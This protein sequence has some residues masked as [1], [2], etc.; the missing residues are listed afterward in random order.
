MKKMHY[1]VLEE[2]LQEGKNCLHE[3]DLYL[4]EHPDLRDS[5]FYSKNQATKR[6]KMER[7]LGEKNVSHSSSIILLVSLYPLFSS[8]QEVRETCLFGEFERRNGVLDNQVFLFSLFESF[9][10]LKLAFIPVFFLPTCKFYRKLLS[11]NFPFDQGRVNIIH[12]QCPA[13]L[14]FIS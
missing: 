3:A 6:T 1:Q 13:G 10:F 2:L 5:R 9:A 12:A 11:L 14:N 7:L 8:L 4:Q